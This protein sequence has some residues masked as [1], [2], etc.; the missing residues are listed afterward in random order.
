ML[1]IIFESCFPMQY[2]TNNVSNSHWITTRIKISCK[3]KKFLYIMSKRTNCLKIKV[4]YNR[5]CGMLW[6]VIRKAEAVY[7]NE[8]LTLSTNLKCL[9]SFINNEIGTAS[10]KKLTQTEFKL[11][12]KNVSMK[13][14]AKIFNNYFINSVDELITQ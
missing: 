4:H 11:G 5:Y 2:V 7:Y 6:K 14:P 10:N 8:M 13:Q 12:I 1:L 3:H 9:G